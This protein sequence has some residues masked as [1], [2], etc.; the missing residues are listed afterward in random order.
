MPVLP[1]MMFPFSTKWTTLH[2]S[3]SCFLLVA[4][5][6]T[7]REEEKQVEFTEPSQRKEKKAFSTSFSPLSLFFCPCSFACNLQKC[8]RGKRRERG[9]GFPPS[10]L[11][12]GLSFFITMR[13][14]LELK[15]FQY[16]LHPSTRAFF[17]KLLVT[18]NQSELDKVF[19][20]V[21]GLVEKCLSWFR[22]LLHQY[23]QCCH[24]NP[25]KACLVFHSPHSQ[26]IKGLPSFSSNFFRWC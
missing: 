16:R 13:H 7:E 21:A 22:D 20:L 25:L 9:A 26:H 12:P 2:A 3:S 24:R 23:F 6:K 1:E 15:G 8:P 18:S 10:S 11:S 5:R 4:P 14:K 19:Y 17:F